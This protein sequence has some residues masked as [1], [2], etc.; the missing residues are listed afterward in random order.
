MLPLIATFDFA[1]VP[2]VPKAQVMALTAGD[3]WL[4]LYGRAL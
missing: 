3:E 1:A 4:A 2:M